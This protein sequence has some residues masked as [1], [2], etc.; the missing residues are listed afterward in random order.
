M[1]IVKNKIKMSK[2]IKLVI[3]KSHGC[4]KKTISKLLTRNHAISVTSIQAGRVNA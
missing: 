3:E 2:R 4:H 1:L